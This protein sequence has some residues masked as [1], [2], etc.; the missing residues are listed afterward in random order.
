M[1]AVIGGEFGFGDSFEGAA[2]LCVEF[3][4]LVSGAIFEASVEY[5]PDFVAV[6]EGG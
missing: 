3:A 4:A 5:A 2:F 1:E 6:V